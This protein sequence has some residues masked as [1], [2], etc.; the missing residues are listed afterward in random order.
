MYSSL[1]FSYK[2][3]GTSSSA[4]AKEYFSTLGTHQITFLPLSLDVAEHESTD[5]EVLP[6]KVESGSDLIDMVFRKDRVEDRKQWLLNC[7]TGI[8]LDYKE[9]AGNGLRYSDFINREYIQFSKYDND[10]SIPHLLDG[11]KTSQRKVLF[12]CLKRNLTTEAKVAQLTGYIA[13][14]SAYHHGEQSLQGT[15]VNMAQDFVVST[16]GTFY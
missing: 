15:I 8:F 7:P 16:I 2:G 4:E 3:L 10:R 5:D 9:V 11:F 14:H 6:D 13:E 1:S 12:G